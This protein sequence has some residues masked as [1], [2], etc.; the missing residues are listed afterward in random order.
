MNKVDYNALD[1][2]MEKSKVSIIYILLISAVAP[3]HLM[4]Y[5]PFFSA[6]NFASS[7]D[8][9][10]ARQYVELDLDTIGLTFW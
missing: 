6:K 4:L 7:L 1:V 5:L 3:I 10:Q 8:P 9:Y 2:K